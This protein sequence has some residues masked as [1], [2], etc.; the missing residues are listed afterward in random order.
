MSENTQV[1]TSYGPIGLYGTSSSVI[2]TI[3]L[4]NNGSSTS[5]T[6][7]S[8]SESESKSGEAQSTQSTS[9]SSLIP[10]KTTTPASSGSIAGSATAK[11]SASSSHKSSS[12]GQISTGALAGGIVGAFVG[13][14]LLAFLV[15]FLFFRKRRQREAPV[16]PTQNSHSTSDAATKGAAA[17]FGKN[18]YPSTVSYSTNDA[19]DAPAAFAA[20]SFKIP[21]IPPPADDQTV[22]TKIESLFDQIS[23]HIDNYYVR[24][25]ESSSIASVKV[26]AIG[27]YDSSLLPRSLFSFLSN[28]KTQRAALTHALAYLLLEAIRP[29]SGSGSLL[30]P[31]FR[32]APSTTRLAPSERG[33]L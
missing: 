20:T 28:S 26:D 12:S 5:V 8:T 31:F 2:F 3:T 25:D 4:P 19:F 10:S 9:S 23:L 6:T 22:S 16:H 30:P 18:L 11:P 7:T 27:Q 24:L 17:V 15:A 21:S 29:E 13:G 33:N 14:C 1:T 32:W